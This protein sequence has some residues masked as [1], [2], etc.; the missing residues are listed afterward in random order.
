MKGI[1]TFIRGTFGLPIGVQFLAR[2]RPIIDWLEVS[3]VCLDD[4][5]FT[6]KY[7]T[8]QDSQQGHISVVR[9]IMANELPLGI[10]IPHYY[11]FEVSDQEPLLVGREQAGSCTLPTEAKAE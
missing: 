9:K 8:E 6:K 11:P 5:L 2:D 3:T 4:M 10:S 7:A 1:N